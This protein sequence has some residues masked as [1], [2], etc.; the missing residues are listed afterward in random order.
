M[1]VAEGRKTQGLR[2]VVIPK[3]ES[4]GLERVNVD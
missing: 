1:T 3:V 2:F 4:F